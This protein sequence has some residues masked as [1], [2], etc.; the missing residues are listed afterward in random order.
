MSQAPKDPVTARI[1]LPSADL[2]NFNISGS[3]LYDL[4]GKYGPIRQVRLGT[5]T[6]LKTKGTAY[7]VFESPDDAKEAINALNGFHLME[8][9]IV[10]LY[11]Q[12]VKQQASQLAKAEIR[13]RE[14]ELEM[15]KRRLGMTD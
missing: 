14:Q 3:D 13:A 1:L 8:R 2:R 5:S 9:Y 7:V 10:V 4:F 11:H 6:E 15:E 12:P